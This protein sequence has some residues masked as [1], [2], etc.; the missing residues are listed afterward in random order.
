MQSVFNNL[1]FNTKNVIFIPPINKWTNQLKE[2]GVHCIFSNMYEY[3]RLAYFS[4][5][6]VDGGWVI[7]QIHNISQVNC[8]SLSTLNTAVSAV[9]YLYDPN[10]LILPLNIPSHVRES[11]VCGPGKSITLC[12]KFKFMLFCSLNIR[13][14]VLGTRKT[15]GSDKVLKI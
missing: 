3:D 7:L 2:N 9:W 4:W 5:I 15:R 6:L 13:A 12:F 14:S 8:F 10:W 11:T 1:L